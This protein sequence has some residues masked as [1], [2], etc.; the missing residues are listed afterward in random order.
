MSKD[1]QQPRK[2]KTYNSKN[3]FTENFDDQEMEDAINKIKSNPNFDQS[4]SSPEVHGEK[5]SLVHD[6]GSPNIILNQDEE[7][8]SF[9]ESNWKF[10]VRYCKLN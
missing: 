2:D 5:Q 1:K 8:I 6:P 4:N 9:E 7:S 10:D 3:F